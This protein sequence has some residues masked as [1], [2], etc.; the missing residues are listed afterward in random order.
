M[1]LDKKILVA[2]DFSDIAGGA[3]N[4]GLE[5]ARAFS[6]PLVL[7]HVYGVPGTVYERVDLNLTADFV[8]SLESSARA[9]LNQEAAR[10]ADKGVEISVVLK[11]GVA[12]ETIVETAS[13]VDAG[14][15][16]IGTHGRRGVP[17]AVLGSVA[18]RVV[19]VSR[20]PVLTIR[21]AASTAAN[22]AT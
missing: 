13:M 6:V 3:A 15:I 12:W 10:L 22:P 17:R 20:L 4:V 14:L 18:E 1:W 11:P 7:L 2:T 8:R 5:L 21:E 16:V 19:R 9:T